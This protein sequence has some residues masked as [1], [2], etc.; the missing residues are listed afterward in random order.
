MSD[1][2]EIPASAG[3]EIILGGDERRAVRFF[4]ALFE[5]VKATFRFADV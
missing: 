1:T 4:S 5:M 3:V 2:E